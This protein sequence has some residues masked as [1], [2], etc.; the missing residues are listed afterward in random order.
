MKKSL[1]KIENF[2]LVVEEGLSELSYFRIN[3]RFIMSFKMEIFWVFFLLRI[4][5]GSTLNYDNRKS[6]L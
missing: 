3:F 2:F 4:W 1:E 6:F 5:K